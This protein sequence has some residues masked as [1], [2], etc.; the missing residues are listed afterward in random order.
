MSKNPYLYENFSTFIMHFVGD[1]LPENW[2]IYNASFIISV[3]RLTET[4]IMKE[5]PDD[6]TKQIYAGVDI[7]AGEVAV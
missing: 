1:L 5:V 2:T 3:G 6:A 7:S 4:C